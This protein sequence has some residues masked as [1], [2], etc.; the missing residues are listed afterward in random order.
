[1]RGTAR[2][3]IVIWISTFTVLGQTSSHPT[4]CST[5]LEPENHAVVV[6]RL[7]RY[8]DSGEYDREIRD[9]VDDARDYLEARAK[10]TSKDEK[11]AAVFDIDETSLSNWDVLSGCGFCSYPSQLKLYP[12]AQGVAIVPVLELFNYAKKNGIAVFFITGRQNAQRD[13]TIKNLTDVGYSGWTDLITQPDGNKQ[14][15][16]VFKSQE[17]QEVE[18][19]GYRIVL[20]IGD[21]ASDLAGCC[22][23]RIFKLPNPFYLVN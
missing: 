5:S 9:V 2:L 13:A 8:H 19:K 23:E 6:D 21:Q 22:A 20:N 7:V 17:R 14:P 16:R 15:A 18:N 1:V 3:L 4:H 10:R 12:N 11:L